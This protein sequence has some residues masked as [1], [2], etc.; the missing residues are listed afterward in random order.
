MVEK[1][2]KPPKKQKAEK[3]ELTIQ[4]KMLKQYPGFKSLR[5]PQRAAKLD[6]EKD[7][8]G[9]EEKL[10]N[11]YGFTKEEIQTIVKHK[12]SVLL[13]EQDPKNEGIQALY[14]FFVEAK[15]QE[16]AFIRELV[17][18]YPYVL[19]KKIEDFENFYKLMQEK[20]NLND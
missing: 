3:K 8:L 14:K 19:G 7:I 20:F 18:K 12:P 2:D 6:F 13:F 4:E 5:F 9:A 15:K 11:T 10:M 16:P 1:G 17:T